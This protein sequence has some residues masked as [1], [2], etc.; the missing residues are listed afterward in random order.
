MIEAGY[1]TRVWPFQRSQRISELSDRESTPP[2]KE[3]DVL[4]Q[5]IVVAV[6]LSA[7]RGSSFGLGQTLGIANG[8]GPS[9]N[10]ASQ[11]PVANHRKHN[12]HC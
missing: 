8:Y 2:G 9:R 4:S 10:G 3:H 11:S 5:R 1:H 7:D 6:A 12:R